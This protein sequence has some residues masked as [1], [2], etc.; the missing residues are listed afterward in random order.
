MKNLSI[1]ISKHFFLGLASLE[2]VR[3]S[4]S[5]SISFFLIIIDLKVI[6]KKLL[7]L[8]DLIK[9]QIFR[10]YKLTEVIMVIKDKDLIF[11]TL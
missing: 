1:L 2:E 4:I 7:G 6:S 3:Q 11:A 10:I 8:V 5:Y 9:A